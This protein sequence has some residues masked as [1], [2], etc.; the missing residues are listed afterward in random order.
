[1]R[2]GTLATATRTNWVVTAAAPPVL[3]G[4]LL[5]TLFA[6]WSR[7]GCRKRER[8]PNGAVRGPSNST[9]A[10]RRKLEPVWSPP[11]EVP[12]GYPLC[13]RLRRRAVWRSISDMPPQIP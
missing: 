5:F 9:P 4:A 10:A 3:P 6:V 8:P 13:R 12:C 7:G 11:G 2:M 1:M